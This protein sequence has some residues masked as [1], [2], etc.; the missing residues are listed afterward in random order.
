MEIEPALFSNQPRYPGPSWGITISYATEPKAGYPFSFS[1][2][3]IIGKFRSLVNFV[4]V[5]SSHTYVKA[6]YFGDRKMSK[7]FSAF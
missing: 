5:E 6:E 1:H 3:R 2:L 7:N 4:N